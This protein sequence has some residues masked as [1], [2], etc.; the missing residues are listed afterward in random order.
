MQDTQKLRARAEQCFLWSR[1]ASDPLVRTKF[2]D[3]G[4]GYLALAKEFETVPI[5]SY[6][7]AEPWLAE[8]QVFSVR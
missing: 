8:P 7:T 5:Y 3:L 2:A 4:S 6:G 1:V